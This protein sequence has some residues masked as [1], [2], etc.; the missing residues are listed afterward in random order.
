MSLA[1]H[2]ATLA[3]PLTQ[4]GFTRTVAS[5]PR[6]GGAGN[7]YLNEFEDEVVS[8]SDNTQTIKLRNV[9]TIQLNSLDFELRNCDGTLPL[10]LGAPAAFVLHI[11]GKDD[12][13]LI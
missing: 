11:D 9:E 12:D 10:D 4:H 8:Y 2:A 3:P 7:T 1:T 5:I 6:Y 13:D